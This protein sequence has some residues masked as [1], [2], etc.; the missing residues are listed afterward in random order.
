MAPILLSPEVSLDSLPHFSTIDNEE[1]ERVDQRR[2]LS[3]QSL[4]GYYERVYS[5]WNTDRVE[6]GDAV[7]GDGLPDIKDGLQI[8]GPDGSWPGPDGYVLGPLMTGQNDSVFAANLSMP[9]NGH[10]T[11][12]AVVDYHSYLYSSPSSTHSSSYFSIPL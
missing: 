9:M 3:A 10:I 12:G 11:A 2:R 4:T 7:N 6:E 5:E 1:K 8:A